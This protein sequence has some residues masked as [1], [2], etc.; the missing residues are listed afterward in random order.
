MRGYK[1]ISWKSAK[2]MMS[3]PNFLRTLMDIDFDAITQNQVKTVR[4]DIT[5]NIQY[6]LVYIIILYSMYY[7]SFSINEFIKL[8]ISYL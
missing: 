5:I 4:G 3:E 1:E 8:F 2:A 6:I 7:M